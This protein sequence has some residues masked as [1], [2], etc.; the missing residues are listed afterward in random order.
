M[1]RHRALLIDGTAV[2][3]LLLWFAVRNVPAED[4]MASLQRA[5]PGWLAPFLLALALFCWLKAVR[6]AAL[7]QTVCPARAR[8]LLAPVVIGY[9]GTGLLPMQLGELGRA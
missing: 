4:L 9:M 6:W 7:L 8:D 2:S 3:V 5:S 1:N